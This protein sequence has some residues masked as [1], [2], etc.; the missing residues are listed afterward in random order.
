VVVVLW[1]WIYSSTA[2]SIASLP[3]I[4]IKPNQKQQA[5]SAVFIGSALVLIDEVG[6]IGSGAWSVPPA[7]RWGH[8]CML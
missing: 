2:Q 1:L 5:L 6:K 8:F 3:V 4:A 7:R